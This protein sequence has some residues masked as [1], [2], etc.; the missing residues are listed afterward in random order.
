MNE[1]LEGRKI[2][3]ATL[4]ADGHFN[5]LTGL[6]RHLQGA[7]CEVRWYTSAAYQDKLDRLG[8]PL[9]PLRQALDTSGQHLDEL[10]PA[11]VAMADPVEKLNFDMINGLVNR[12]PEYYADLRDVYESFRFD[13]VVTDSLF[14]AI[15]FVKRKLGVPVVAIGVVPLAET[16]T[17]LAP[18]GMA[19]APAADAAGRAEHA[20]LRAFAQNVLFKPSMDAF[21]A[22]LKAHGMNL[23]PSPPFDLL[24]READLYLQIGTPGFEYARTDLGA[25]VRFVGA[26]LPFSPAA[27]GKPWL[28]ERLRQF[29]HVVL[30]TQGTVEKDTGK[31]LEPTLAAFRDT[32][33]LVVAATGGSGTRELREKYAAANVIVEDFIPFDQVMPYARVFVTNGGYGG[34]LLG[35]Q[36]GLPMVAAG[37]HEG[38]NEVCKRIGYFRL[39]IDLGTETPSPPAIREAVAAVLA[40]GTYRENV[41]RLAAEFASYPA[42]ELCAGYIAG[43][44][45]APAR[46]ATR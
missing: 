8:I 30:V 45:A 17:D 44:L 39:G 40:D 1:S 46:P 41:A 6:A 10:F 3:F 14:P 38:K 31:I 12:A 9:Y 25:N 24:I 34:T 4:P 26:L 20:T 27:E 28:D 36:H 37:V 15:P 13:L 22:T 42:R 29:P 33:V 5:P 21:D 19:L 35:I 7:G 2:L 32:D 16:S 11:R 23:P 43:L 18:Y